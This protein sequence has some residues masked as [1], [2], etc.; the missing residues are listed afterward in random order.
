M[1]IA[2]GIALAS[3]VVASLV[4]AFGV[5]QFVQ[6]Q[7]WKRTEV[8]CNLVHKLTQYQDICAL[9]SA[10]GLVPKAC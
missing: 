6:A 5:K 3:P 1:R 7:N 2:E 8:A 10:S 9:Q 4:F